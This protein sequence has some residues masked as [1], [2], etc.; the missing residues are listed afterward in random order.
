MEG[1]SNGEG[2]ICEQINIS[3]AAIPNGLGG[4]IHTNYSYGNLRAEVGTG[5]GIL[6]FGWMQT[7]QVE[8][9]LGSY[10]EFRQDWPYVGLPSMTKKTLIG[11]GNNGVLS[12]TVNTYGC[13]DPAANSATACTIAAGR[14][15]FVHLDQSEESSWDY[16]GTV[17]PVIT[18]KTDYDNWG[19]ATK[20]D[21]ATNDG[22]KKSTIN[23]YSNDSANWYLG[24]LLRSSVS[25]TS[26]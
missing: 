2:Q 16:N 23:N 17:L 14:R 19:N 12:Q 11:G 21:V 26:P 5:R 9:G 13:S 15:Y 7:T 4:V 18:T 6:G 20:V 22:F 8:T 10:T 1:G 3:A 25:S 24:R